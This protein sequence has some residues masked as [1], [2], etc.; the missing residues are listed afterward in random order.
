MFLPRKDL[1]ACSLSTYYLQAFGRVCT[2][3][4]RIVPA[5]RRE[6]RVNG[7]SLTING[8]QLISPSLRDS[9]GEHLWLVAANA[10]RDR[11]KSCGQGPAVARA[12]R[13]T[14]CMP[15]IGSI[16]RDL[17]PRKCVAEYLPK[18]VSEHISRG[19]EAQDAARSVQ[20]MS[21]SA[22]KAVRDLS[23]SAPM[24]S[25]R[26]MP[27]TCVCDAVQPGSQQ[28]MGGNAA[29]PRAG[30]SLSDGNATTPRVWWI[31]AVA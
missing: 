4:S 19:R 31:C 30:K 12:S 26:S 27:L 6:T 29:D 25:S 28:M 3:L 1:P 21:E 11:D 23:I 7:S 5:R 13:Q 22:E 2:I 17:S 24:Q 16:G 18:A 9:T 15:I 14:V 10:L 8:S 20:R